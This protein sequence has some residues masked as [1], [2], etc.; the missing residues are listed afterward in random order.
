MALHYI[1]IAMIRDP[2]SLTACGFLMNLRPLST[3]RYKTWVAVVDRL[4]LRMPTSH[5]SRYGLGQP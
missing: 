2:T 4:Y 5:P 1:E 3:A